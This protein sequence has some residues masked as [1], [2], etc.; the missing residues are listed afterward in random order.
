MMMVMSGSDAHQESFN[1]LKDCLVSWIGDDGLAYAPVGPRRPWDIVCTEDYANVYAQSRMMLAMMALHGFDGDTAWL[2]RI[3]A[4][5]D[6]LCRIAIDRGDYA[7]YPLGMAGERGRVREGYCYP[8]SGWYCTD[9]AESEGEGRERSMFVYQAGPIRAL[10]RWY[11]MSGDGK[12]LE[13][14][15]KLVRY[16]MQER[17]WG[18]EYGWPNVYLPNTLPFVK[19]AKI[20]GYE[21]AHFEG[22]FHGH[23]ATLLALIEYAVATG[24]KDPKEFVR[25][26]YE[27][28]RNHGIARFGLFGETCTISDMIALAIK[29]TDAG[30]GDYWDDADGYVRNQL[31]EQQVLDAAHLEAVSEAGPPFEDRPGRLRRLHA[32]FPRGIPEGWPPAEDRRYITTER[33]IEKS[34]GI[35]WDFADLGQVPRS[36]SMQCCTPNGALALYFAW[37]GIIR[38]APRGHVQVNLLLN[39]ASPWM[40][41]DSYLP[42]EGRVVLRNKTA[43]SLSLR[44]PNWADRSK[45]A[46]RADGAERDL[47]WVGNYAI[48][49]GLKRGDEIVFTFPVQEQTVCH[50]VLTRQLWTTDP[51]RD[52]NPESSTIKYTCH[53]KGNTL[54][55]FSPRPDGRWYPLYERDHYKKDTAPMKGVPRF[56][57]PGVLRW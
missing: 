5:A 30:I 19:A 52:V 14:A 45:V 6:G 56:V 44:I 32:Q 23:T 46:C 11:E 7:Y 57:A 40:D 3:G 4:M 53:L 15:G 18:S 10:T 1:G 9:E 51:R 36:S 13:T 41:V 27:Y 29:L 22:H 37:E 8:R 24:D 2:D 21:H 39:R 12:A 48:L 31:V 47:R 16:I 34:L 33:V 55:D 43:R 38:E 35:F 54:V 42:C 17:F 50:T 26:G 28:G 49:D 20:V 25:F